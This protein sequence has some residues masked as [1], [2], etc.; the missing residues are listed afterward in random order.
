MVFITVFLNTS[1]NEQNHATDN[2]LTKKLSYQAGFVVVRIDAASVS[3]V[4]AFLGVS[5]VIKSFRAGTA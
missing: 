5:D 2:T 1:I 3:K 4:G